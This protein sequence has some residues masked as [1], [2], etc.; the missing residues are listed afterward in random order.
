[1][2]LKVINEEH[3]DRELRKVAASAYSP[4]VARWLQTAVK[5]HLL[6]LEGA[7]RDENFRVY[8]PASVKP[9]HGEPPPFDKLPDWAKA[10]LEGGETLH[11]FDPI[12]VQSRQTWK[13]IRTITVWMNAYPHEV[14]FEDAVKQAE[15]W[16]AGVGFRQ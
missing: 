8:D 10:A 14:M 9:L 3:I 5:A 2:T 7:D 1:M 13:R 12:Q 11:W 16:A 15:V 4:I 6:N